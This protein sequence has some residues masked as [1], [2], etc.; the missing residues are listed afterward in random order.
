MTASRSD[1]HGRRR[2]RLCRRAYLALHWTGL[3]EPPRPG[4]CGP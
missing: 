4:G 1:S 3:H 2:L